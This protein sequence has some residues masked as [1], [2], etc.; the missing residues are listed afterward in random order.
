MAA[1]ECA[2]CRGSLQ[3]HT[4]AMT[5]G[6]SW[7]L[8]SFFFAKFIKIAGKIWKIWGKFLHIYGE[9]YFV[10]KVQY[11]VLEWLKNKIR[12]PTL[13]VDDA[14][15][16]SSTLCKPYTLICSIKLI[17]YPNLYAAAFFWIFHQ[18]KSH[19]DLGGIFLEIFPLKFKFKWIFM[20]K[21]IKIWVKCCVA[22]WECVVCP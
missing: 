8:Y 19:H 14:N 13:D 20:W 12:E 22:A 2:A 11:R 3:L 21:W 18:R 7:I 17:S 4:P 10:R 9:E 5:L 16:N 6:I 15:G 1:W